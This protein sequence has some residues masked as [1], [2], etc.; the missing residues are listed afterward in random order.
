M[1]AVGSKVN[2]IQWRS[3]IGVWLDAIEESS[4]FGRTE[5]CIYASIS[6]SK[7]DL[8]LVY[9]ETLRKVSTSE[10]A[11]SFEWLS[12]K[13][14]YFQSFH[15]CAEMGGVDYQ[16]GGLVHQLGMLTAV[17]RRAD[18]RSLHGVF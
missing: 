15:C 16:L 3:W 17:L 9:G 6:S 10:I 1:L 5:F 12:N 11:A 2:E 7:L 18:A 14:L 8:A 13:Y 4:S